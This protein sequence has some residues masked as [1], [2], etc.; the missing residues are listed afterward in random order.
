M[1]NHTPRKTLKAA[2]SLKAIPIDVAPTI[3][4]RLTSPDTDRDME[5]HFLQRIHTKVP[6]FIRI[7]PFTWISSEEISHIVK[8]ETGADSPPP[9]RR[10][11]LVSGI[12][13]P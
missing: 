10:R 2:K 7:E 9:P 13:G 8:A 1:R 12:A 6:D 4:P 11:H 3:S 5:L